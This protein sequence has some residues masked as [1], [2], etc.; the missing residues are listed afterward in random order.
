MLLPSPDPQKAVED[1]FR[2][3]FGILQRVDR[4]KD[5]DWITEPL[6]YGKQPPRSGGGS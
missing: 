4:W 3:S 6:T 1:F 5:L 2:S